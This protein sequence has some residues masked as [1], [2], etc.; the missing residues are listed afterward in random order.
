MSD[1][2]EF[3]FSRGEMDEAASKVSFEVFAKL[4]VPL[5]KGF[6]SAGLS[7]PEAAFLTAAYCTLSGS[8]VPSEDP[9]N[10]E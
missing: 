10:G 3:D 6:I 1:E 7:L 8:M 9:E 2:E 4:M 5:Y